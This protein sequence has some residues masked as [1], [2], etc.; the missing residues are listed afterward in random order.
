MTL[1]GFSHL[2]TG[3]KYCYPHA[4]G[5]W[6]T[7]GAE[8]RLYSVLR[9]SIVSLGYGEAGKGWSLLCLHHTENGS[10]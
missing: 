9:D 1:P 6:P 4:E 3:N 10:V 7:K 2:K 5:R 8:E